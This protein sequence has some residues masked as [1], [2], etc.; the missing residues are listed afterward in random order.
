MKFIGGAADETGDELVHRAARRCVSGS[1][2]LLDVAMVH[3]DDAVAH[4]H[5]LDLVVGDVD[6]G[7]L[8]AVVQ[9]GDFCAHLDAELGVEVGEGLVEEEDLGLAHD[10]AAHGDA[11]ALAA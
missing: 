5:G 7:G 4:G 6:H 3:D 10:G 1:V 8:Q 9:L 11:L 2:D